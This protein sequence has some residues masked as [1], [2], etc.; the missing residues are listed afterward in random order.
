ML[1][2]PEALVSGYWQPGM[3]SNAFD[4]WERTCRAPR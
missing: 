3:F 1:A 2:L 4:G